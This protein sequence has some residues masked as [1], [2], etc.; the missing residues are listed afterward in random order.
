MNCSR[1]GVVQ[2]WEC[3]FVFRTN[4][5]TNND[6]V[7]I[8]EFGPFFLVDVDVFEQ[9]LE[10]G[11]AG[12]SHVECF[13]GEERLL[14]EEVV[15]ISIGE[16]GQELMTQSIERRHLRER[17]VPRFVR[18]SIDMRCID[19]SFMIV[20]PFVDSSIFHLIKFKHDRFERFHVLDIL[21]IRDGRFLIIE[22]RKPHPLEMSSIP[23]L[24]PTRNPHRRPLSNKQRFNHSWNL[25]H[26]SNRPSHMIQNFD[27]PNLFPGHRHVFQQL[28]DRMGHIL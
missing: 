23:L 14:I 5:L 11:S 3:D 25:I 7:D 28:H 19:K 13:R 22:R 15:V 24:P 6:F 16:V 18:R 26:K 21:G 10:F 4:G 12:E 8:V 20:E 2:E 17:Q 1:E 9:G 27:L